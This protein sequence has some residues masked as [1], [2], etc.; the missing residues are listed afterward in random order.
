MSLIPSS[1]DETLWLPF[2]WYVE[3]GQ[4]ELNASLDLERTPRAASGDIAD[5]QWRQ[6]PLIFGQAADND[7]SA[8]TDLEVS[9]SGIVPLRL[10]LVLPR[11]AERA[12]VRAAVLKAYNDYLADHVGEAIDEGALR[13]YMLS[14]ARSSGLS[15]PDIEELVNDIELPSPLTDN[16]RPGD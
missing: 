12:D 13:D 16:V 9:Y 5:L 14:V 3:N 4:L 8:G 10:R 2:V 6:A 1:G 7:P 15:L 11:S